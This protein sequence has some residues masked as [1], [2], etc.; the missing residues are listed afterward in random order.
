MTYSNEIQLKADMNG[1]DRGI[2]HYFSI[3]GEILRLLELARKPGDRP[4]EDELAHELVWIWGE[5]E[6][7]AAFRLLERKVSD[8]LWY[9]EQMIAATE[10]FSNQLD[11]QSEHQP[12]APEAVLRGV[13]SFACCSVKHK[14][15]RLRV[16]PSPCPQYGHL[17][18]ADAWLH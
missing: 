9:L 14:V 15:Q 4:Q 7:A 10:E 16:K 5:K 3:R 8:R 1:F 13:M 2:D 18:D 11:S 6:A 17:L 12:H